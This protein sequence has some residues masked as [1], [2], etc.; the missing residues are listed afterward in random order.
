MRQHVLTTFFTVCCLTT[1]LTAIPYGVQ[2]AVVVL[3][4]GDRMTGRIV[5][6]ENMRLEI[7]LPAA[8]IIRIKW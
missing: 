6:M 8:G 4:N 3:K 2:A 1:V 5:K 7:D